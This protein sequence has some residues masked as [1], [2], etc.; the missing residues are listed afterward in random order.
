M[1]AAIRAIG[2]PQEYAKTSSIRFAS[3]GH[4]PV[5]FKW[6]TLLNEHCVARDVITLAAA[7]CILY[8]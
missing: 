1:V 6:K 3:F 8:V 5:F 2:S 7:L 4:I